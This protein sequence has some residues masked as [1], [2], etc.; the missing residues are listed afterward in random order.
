MSVSRR[1]CFVTF[2]QADR[3]YVDSFVAKFSD[4]FIPRVLGVS[5][6]DD[7]INSTDYDYVMRRIRERYL[8]DSSVTIVMAGRCTWARKYVDWEVASSLRND[9]INRRSGL[10]GI[11]LPYMPTGVPTTVPDRFHD[12]I[13]AG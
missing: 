9:P 12:N 13:K 5:D 2:H 4:V 7:F 11:R 1:K 3:A 8:T 10:F 6:I